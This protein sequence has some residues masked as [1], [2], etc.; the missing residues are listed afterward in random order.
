[1]QAAAAAGR[2]EEEAGGGGGRGGAEA[3]PELLCQVASVNVQQQ[4]RGVL[5]GG[6]V[7]AP[8]LSTGSEKKSDD[9]R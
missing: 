4:Q 6:Q 3:A 5:L 2:D 7:G 8:H 9:C 1:M